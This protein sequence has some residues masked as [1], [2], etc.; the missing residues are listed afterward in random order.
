MKNLKILIVLV[1]TLIS[2]SKGS[3]L[4]GKPTLRIERS[5]LDLILGKST[6]KAPVTT[7]LPPKKPNDLLIG[8]CEDEDKVM[9]E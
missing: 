4:D 2:L 1:I 3:P 8:E 6:T 5:F 9:N 7:T